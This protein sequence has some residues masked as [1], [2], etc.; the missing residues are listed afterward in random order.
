MLYRIFFLLIHKAI[1]EKQNHR[2][3]ELIMIIN[4]LVLIPLLNT[5]H[6]LIYL[7]LTTTLWIGTLIIPN[8]QIKKLNASVD[9]VLL[10]MIELVSGRSGIETKQCRFRSVFLTHYINIERSYGCL[11]VTS[12][13]KTLELENKYCS[14]YIHV[15]FL[16]TLYILY[17]LMRFKKM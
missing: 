9:C 14:L 16:C 2:L 1:K 17:C 15:L 7:I 4:T 13:V 3:L 10:K 12:L 8:L 11:K 6:S 5:S